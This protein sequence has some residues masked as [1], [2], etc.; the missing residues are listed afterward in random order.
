MAAAF[1][2]VFFSSARGLAACRGR[3]FLVAKAAWQRPLLKYH[4]CSYFS[5]LFAASES[6]IHMGG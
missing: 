6:F 1:I 3:F 2:V 5:F 4:P